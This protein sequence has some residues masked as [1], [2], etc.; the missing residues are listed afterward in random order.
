MS[1]QP[2]LPPELFH[3]VLASE[4]LVFDNL[5][6]FALVVCSLV[7]FFLHVVSFSALFIVAGMFVFL[8]ILLVFALHFV[9]VFCIFLQV[10]TSSLI[11]LAAMTL[12]HAKGLVD[13]SNSFLQSCKFFSLWRWHIFIGCA[14]LFVD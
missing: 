13:Q 5:V 3:S 4:A 6:V 11:Y 7:T 9:S 2:F 14:S 12:L 10:V 1:Q 8:A